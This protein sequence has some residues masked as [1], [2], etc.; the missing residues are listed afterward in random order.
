[1][2]RCARALLALA[3]LGWARAQD[4]LDIDEEDEEEDLGGAAADEGGIAYSK[5][6][7]KLTKANFGAS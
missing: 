7:I 6:V 1:M 2:G 5:D 4:D 3:L